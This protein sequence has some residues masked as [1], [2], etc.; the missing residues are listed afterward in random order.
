MARLDDDTAVTATSDDDAYTATLSPDWAIWGPMG[1]YIAAVALRAAGAA[2]RRARPASFSAQFHGVADFAPIEL[3]T[4]LLRTTRV[5]TSVEVDIV[6]N[7]KSVLRATVWGVDEL[8]G[9]EHHTAI[10]PAMGSPLDYP[11]IDERFAQQAV[12]K[13]SGYP[14]WDRLQQRPL[15]WVDDWDNTPPGDPTADSWNR[16]VDAETFDDAWTDACRLLIVNDIYAWVAV[17]PAHRGSDT[18]QRFYAPTIELTTRFVGDARDSAW[19][20]CHAEA[21][22]AANGIVVHRGEV[23]TESGQLDAL[24]GSTLLSRPLAQQPT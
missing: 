20:F 8:D 6:Q 15:D 13:R 23:W 4:R 3:R 10:R 2:C 16:F 14:F 12:N 19:L 11:T 17:G 1:G 18:M 24:G 9:V 22:A 7:D 21:P 5:A